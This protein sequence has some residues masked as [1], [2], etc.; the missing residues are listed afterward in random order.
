MTVSSNPPGARD[1]DFFVGTWSAQQRRLKKRLQNNHEWETF[2]ATVT[3]QN[4]PGGLANFDTFVAES[5][6]PGFMGMT[7]RVFN[8]AT[9]LWSIFWIT[10]SGE[11]ID[12]QTGNLAQPVVGRFNGDIGIFECDDVFEGRPIRVRFEWTRI[13][14]HAARWQQAFSPDG[15]KTWEVN[16]VMEFARQGA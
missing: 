6:R 12:P 13:N 15:G 16:W 3:M 4:L 8:P 7:F 5:W 1:F 2:T 10:N 11:G 14:A 9:G